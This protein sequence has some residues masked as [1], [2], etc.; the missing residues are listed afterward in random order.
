MSR[1]V[2][3]ALLGSLAILFAPRFSASAADKNPKNSEAAAA[4][5]QVAAALRAEIAGENDRRAELLASAVRTAPDL[6]EANWHL[7]RVQIAGKWR[8]LDDARQEAA[9][10]QQLA[11]YRKLRDEA[12]DN[13]KLLRGL[14]RWCLKNGHE[15]LARL[16]YT[17]LLARS[18]NDAEAQKEAIERLDLRYVG[19]SW[20]TAEDLKA[21][22]DKAR[23][24][25]DAIRK[26]RPRIKRLQQ[27]VDAG[28]Y[29]LRERAMKE[30]KQIDE[31]QC[32][33]VLE[34]F[35]TDGGADFQQAAVEHLARFPDYSATEALVRY[36]VLSEF[37]NARDKAIA[38]LKSRSKYEYVPLL[39]CG[40]V[41]PIKS[42]FQIKTLP[43]GVITYTHVFMRETPQQKLVAVANNQIVPSF[44]PRTFSV[45]KGSRGQILGVVFDDTMWALENRLAQ[46]TFLKARE[47]EIAASL[48]AQSVHFSNKRVFQALTASTD[49][50]FRDDPQE[51]WQWWQDYNEYHWPQQTYVSYSNNFARYQTPPPVQVIKG[52]SCFLAG[53]LVQ[54][55][56]GRE[57]IESI[58]P[59]D[60]VLAQDQNSGELTYKLVLRTT[61]RPPAKMVC[62]R[63]GGDEITTTLGHPFWVDG[64]GW[65]MAKEL[66]DGDLLHSLNGAVRIDKVENAGEEKAYN[67]VVDEF[68]TYFVGQQGLLVHDN[69]FRR[70]TRAIVPGL[71]AD[72]SEATLVKK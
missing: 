67:L 41:A 53:T 9:N 30:L 1:L 60:R 33:P 43:N 35:L 49:Q 11:E 2:S 25:D 26:L 48:D 4:R 46:E 6:P 59:G 5:E 56:I 55:Q 14:A 38:A 21:Q 47:N 3:C 69:E 7:G 20:M 44:V 58:R 71:T 40:L 17:Q 72:D 65:K 8:T 50:Q 57:P 51:W 19:G 27:A 23:A 42:Q 22:E 61:L 34:T 52:Q 13:P 16:H 36:A 70:P 64:R 68:N 18:D 24:L 29:A 66:K 63:A 45:P 12:K 37:V 54:T 28:D 31:P 39:L 15:D 62:I 10:D 32:I